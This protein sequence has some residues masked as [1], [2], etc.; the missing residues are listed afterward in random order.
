MLLN[1]D[2]DTKCVVDHSNLANYDINQ[3]C[4]YT[5][6]FFI[7]IYIYLTNSY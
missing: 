4:G 3:S 2:L 5:C 1:I 6:R 7:Y